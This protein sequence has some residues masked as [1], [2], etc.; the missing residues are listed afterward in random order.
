M[1]T[2]PNEE[3]GEILRRV[4]RAE[5]DSVVPTPD[6]L[7]RIRAGVDER[8]QRRFGWAW[9]TTGWQRPAVAIGAAAAVLALGVSA[10]HTID[11]F[12][13]AGN[14]GSAG[15]GGHPTSAGP[16]PTE[17]LSPGASQ[18]PTDPADPTDHRPGTIGTPQPDASA[19]TPTCLPEGQEPPRTVRAPSPP[20][21]IDPDGSVSS[22]LPP[23]EKPGDK[24]KPEPSSS[25]TITVEPS[26][27]DQPTA[28]ETPNPDQSGKP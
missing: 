23:C 8:T 26:P 11:R 14:R 22:K 6:G 13:S 7:E 25:A 16:A 15:Q 3:Y 17:E 9:F 18:E 4:L 12:T 10:P 5:A 24:P 20:G 1:T 21:S 19:G 2:D 27:S 28:T